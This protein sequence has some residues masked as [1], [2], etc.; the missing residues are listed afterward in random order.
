MNEEIQQETFL[1]E[2]LLTSR[3]IACKVG[4]DLLRTQ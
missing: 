1:P 4:R 2:L 3:S